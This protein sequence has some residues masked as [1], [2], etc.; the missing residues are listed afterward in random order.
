[1]SFDSHAV[2]FQGWLRMNIEAVRIGSSIRGHGIGQ[3]M[4]NKNS[5]EQDF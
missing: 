4:F 5:C 3:W 2:S 1:M